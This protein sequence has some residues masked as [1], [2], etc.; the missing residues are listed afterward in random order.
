VFGLTDS[1]TTPIARVCES[2]LL[3]PISAST[4][5]GSYAA[6]MAVVN[7]I[8]VA[9]A[10]VKPRRALA[11]FRQS[12]KEYLSSPRWY[13]PAPPPSSVWTG[14]GSRAE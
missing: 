1:D 6:P 8:L 4:F 3:A 11:V 13:D 2:Y 14:R 7:A 9:C 12:E 10:Q 5:T